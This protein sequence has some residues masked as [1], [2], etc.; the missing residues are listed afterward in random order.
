MSIKRCALCKKPAYGSSRGNNK[1]YWVCSDCRL[2]VD[3]TMEDKLQ[4]EKTMQPTESMCDKCKKRSEGCRFSESQRSK[5]KAC[6]D[7]EGKK[8]Q[9]NRR[10]WAK[11]DI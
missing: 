2:K 8:T 10:R 1:E 7:W 5:I 6:S 3:G 9:H 11:F 4:S